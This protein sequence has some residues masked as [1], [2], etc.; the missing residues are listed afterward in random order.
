MVRSTTLDSIALV[1][2]LAFAHLGVV[3]DG[4]LSL[5]IVTCVA[6]H[7]KEVNC[8]LRMSKSNRGVNH[9]YFR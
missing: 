8:Y 6:V 3:A 5:D 9:G 2:R 7:F 1:L 4:G